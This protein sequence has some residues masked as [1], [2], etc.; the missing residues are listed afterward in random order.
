MH[1]LAAFV[2]P[3]KFGPTWPRAGTHSGLNPVRERPITTEGKFR[4]RGGKPAVGRSRR[5]GHRNTCAGTT[6]TP[7]PFVRFG[8]TFT[9]RGEPGATRGTVGL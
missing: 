9:G 4:H 7:G 8:E 3:S 5:L 2:T 1:S 6:R